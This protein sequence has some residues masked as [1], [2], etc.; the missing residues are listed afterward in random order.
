MEDRFSLP[1]P[2]SLS[3]I[4]I[5]RL[6]I[7]CQ[8]GKERTGSLGQ[9]RVSAHLLTRFNRSVIY[10]DVPGARGNTYRHDFKI[11]MFIVLLLT[12]NLSL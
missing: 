2:P 12:I 5:C 3:P 7:S 10:R 8:D 11:E 6:P 4:H 1:P 9:I